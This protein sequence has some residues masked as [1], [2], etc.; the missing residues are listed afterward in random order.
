MGNTL[1]KDRSPR[2]KYVKK[3]P[4]DEVLANGYQYQPNVRIA[5]DKKM[6]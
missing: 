5:Y 1:C 3:S 4:I 6:L 2:R